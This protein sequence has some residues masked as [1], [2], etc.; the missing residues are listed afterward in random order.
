MSKRLDRI[1]QRGDVTL[2]RAD[3]IEEPE[4]IKSPTMTLTLGT[5][6]AATIATLVAAFND[7]FNAIFGQA[8]GPDIKAAVLIAV[9]A[10]WAFIAVADIFSR[11]IA[12]AATETALGAELAAKASANVVLMPTALSAKR[13]K[14]PDEPG[15]LVAALR[16][17]DDGADLVMLV[18]EGKPP[19]WVERD[20]VEFP[21]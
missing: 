19:E 17:G 12:K 9:I 15:F 18:K 21:Q 3:A 5:A 8:A 4:A 16:S 14:G 10:A 1:Y 6:G 13:L 11:A 2:A 20:E 7:S